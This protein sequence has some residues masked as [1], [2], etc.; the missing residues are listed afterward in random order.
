MALF[1]VMWNGTDDLVWTLNGVNRTAS[2]KDLSVRCPSTLEFEF[3]LNW[4]NP[5][6]QQQYNNFH[7]ALATSM[8]LQPQQ[9]ILAGA[10]VLNT[11]TTYTFRIVE[12][13]NVSDVTAKEALLTLVN[14]RSNATQMQLIVDPFTQ[15]LGLQFAGKLD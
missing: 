12:N 14:M 11:I 3:S 1:S 5:L 8:S 15:N 7:A 13:L 6:T 2:A 4:T 9:L 10:T